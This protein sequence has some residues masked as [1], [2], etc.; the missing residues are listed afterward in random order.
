MAIDTAPAGGPAAR[1]ENV[2]QYIKDMSF[3][4]PRSPASILQGTEEPHGEL[5]VQV[6]VRKMGGDNYEVILQFQVESTKEGEVAFLIELHYAGVF[7][8]T[9]FPESE[10]EPALMIECPRILYPFARRVIADVVR[11]GGFP[12]L[13][14][15][16]IDFVQL[17]KMYGPQN[18]PDATKEAKETEAA[19]A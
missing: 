8:V 14:L 15:G 18:Q 17:Y 4:S 11:D 19:D 12:Q 1:I 9:G 6:K 10:L 3:E 7:T 2:T 13:M 5:K 16:P